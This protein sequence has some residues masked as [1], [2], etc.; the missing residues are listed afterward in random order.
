LIR[1]F[2]I[3]HEW[4]LKH[5]LGHFGVH[6]NHY[7]VPQRWTK[8]I[9]ASVLRKKHFDV[10]RMHVYHFTDRKKFPDFSGIEI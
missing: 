2:L 4:S 7:T 1:N 10:S 9:P 5:R 6:S 8:F 3:N